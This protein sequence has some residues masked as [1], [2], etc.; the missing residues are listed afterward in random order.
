MAV[1]I[2]PSSGS[3][4]NIQKIHPDLSPGLTYLFNGQYR[5]ALTEFLNI[6][7]T[8]K[9]FAEKCVL[10]GSIAKCH[11]E[12]GQFQEAI[13]VC[14]DHLDLLKT[15]TTNKKGGQVEIFTKLSFCYLEL[16]YHKECI[17]ISNQ[18][19][20][21]IEEDSDAK[22]SQVKSEILGHMQVASIRLRLF[23]QAVD[24]AKRNFRIDVADL[25]KSFANL[26]MA[27][28]WL[29]NYDQA[30]EKFKHALVLMINHNHQGLLEE[31]SKLMVQIGI[32]YKKQGRPQKAL[33]ILVDAIDVKKRFHGHVEICN[34]DTCCLYLTIGSCFYE[35]NAR[36]KG[37]SYFY[38][39]LMMCCNSVFG[40]LEFTLGCIDDVLNQVV[41]NPEDIDFFMTKI[42]EM[43]SES[44]D[45]RKSLPKGFLT[46]FPIYKN[47][48]GINIHFK[49]MN[50][51]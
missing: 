39:V 50:L 9:S 13:E 33:E 16:G 45:L 43:V 32:C 1:S 10:Y 5:S 6:N 7:M 38:Q 24:L 19:F 4:K 12:I 17:A 18:L 2:F 51:L 28:F 22:S 21:I 15:L 47:A 31:R 11:I 37:R 29:P 25:P 41:F 44:G 8:K 48:K 20:D 23:A 34:P 36:S 46:H 27:Y 35:I 40:G 3:K 26:G 14:L 42:I 30:I 49:N